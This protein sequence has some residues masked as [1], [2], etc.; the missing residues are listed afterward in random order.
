MNLLYFLYDILKKDFKGKIIITV[1]NMGSFGE[2]NGYKLV[3]SIKVESIDST[4]A[5][6]FYHGA[7]IYALTKF[8]SVIRKQSLS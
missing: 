8:H 2:D 5:G 1:E 6:D 7:F 4:G 3:P